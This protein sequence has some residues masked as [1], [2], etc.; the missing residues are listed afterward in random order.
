MK[1]FLLENK[2]YLLAGIGIV[3][4]YF[5][6]L[7]NLTLLPVFADEAIYIRWAQ[8]MRAEE[9]LRFLPLSDGKQP[10]FMWMM[11]PVFKLISDPLFAGRFLSVLSGFGTM[12]GIGVLTFLLFKNKKV[13]LLASFTA[14]LLPFTFFFDRMALVDSML[15]MFGIWTFIF[16]YLSITKNRFDFAMLAGFTLGGAWLTKSPAL[17]FAI[18]LPTL[19]LFSKKHLYTIFYILTTV[20]IGYGFYNI[21]RL[22]PNWHL[23]ASRNL[24]Y[25][26]PLSHFLTSPLDPLKPFLLQSW[27]WIWMM[28]GVGIIVTWLLSYI[29]NAKKYWKEI[30][31][32]TLWFLAPIFI[33]SEFAKVLTARYILFTLPYL[34]IIASSLFL[35]T[36]KLLLKLGI[37]F[38][39]IFI[40]Q[41]IVFNYRLLT[42][43]QKANL[44][45]SERS[46]Y[47]ED[48][49]AGFGI[50]ESTDY[51]KNEYLKN[52]NQVIVVG[53]EGYFGTLPDGAQIYLNN[54]KN[55]IIKGVGLDIKAVD[56][57]L[58]SSKKSGNKTYLLVNTSRLNKSFDMSKVNLIG[59]YKKAVKPDGTSESLLFMEIN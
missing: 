55:I 23:L 54:Y 43:P 20:A 29:V 14:C 10:L 42:D 1:K 53:T 13:A 33:E 2:Y 45:R 50:K 58:L 21:L 52:P 11:I 27:Q 44:P 6:R 19:L 18:L 28:G 37:L 36:N 40:F 26:Y 3:L 31:I 5:V 51:I 9:T 15:S 38:F 35:T 4:L 46:G 22:G 59:S 12:V 41:S 8:V 7:Y 49:T 48:W 57:S 56:S 32:L 25:V 39:S 34:V 30:L 47:L 17:F 16:S 24:D